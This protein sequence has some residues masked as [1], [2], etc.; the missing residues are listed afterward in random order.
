MGIDIRTDKN[1]D[2]IVTD[3]NSIFLQQSMQ[4]LYLVLRDNNNNV[5]T[6][7]RINIPRDNEYG[8]KEWNFKLNFQ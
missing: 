4:G 7:K 8:N 1:K 5:E 6:S 3:E 2:I